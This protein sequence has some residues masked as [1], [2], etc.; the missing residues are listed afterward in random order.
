MA[1]W[2]GGGGAQA[3]AHL[4]NHTTIF[5]KS[6]WVASG[7]GGRLRNKRRRAAGRSG[8]SGQRAVESGA[9]RRGAAAPR[10]G[11]SVGASAF[12]RL[13][14]LGYYILSISCESRLQKQIGQPAL[15]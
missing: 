5:S 13:K 6:C 4:Q 12:A 14:T 3:R 1:Q 11:G 2:A 8:G 15:R 10:S 7:G 9:G